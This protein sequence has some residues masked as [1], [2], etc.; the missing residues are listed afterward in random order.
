[1]LK[2]TIYYPDTTDKWIEK[3]TTE[4]GVLIMEERWYPNG[5]K[6]YTHNFS[7]GKADGV[8]IGWYENGQMMY[9]ENLIGGKIS[10]TCEWWH[11]DGA[12]HIDKTFL[13]DAEV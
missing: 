13:D 10:G 5:Q 1:M 7:D 9:Q 11:E 3:T 4:L 6:Q 2:E 12:K 8:F